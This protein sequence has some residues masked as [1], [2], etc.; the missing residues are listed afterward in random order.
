MGCI[1]SKRKHSSTHDGID[2]KTQPVRNTDRTIYVRDPTSNKQQRPVHNVDSDLLPGQ[3]FQSNDSEEEM[4]IAIYPYEGLHPDDLSFKKGEKMKVLEEYGEWWK[5]KSLST[6]KEGYI[7]SNYVAKLNSLETEDW[8]FKDI[9]RKDA[10]RQLLLPG[11]RVG[12]YLIRES[13]TL[14]GSFSLSVRDYD[15]LHGDVIK[16][17]KIRS[18]D[19]GGYYISPRITFP[20]IT[21]LIKHYQ[22]QPDGLCRRLDKACISTQPQKPWD[23]DAWEIPRESI[24]LVKKLGAGQFGEVWMG[25]YNG[26]TK[27][28]VKTLKPGTMSVQSFIEEANLMKTLQHEKLVRLYA[29]VTKEEPIY[30]VTEFMAKGSL[31]DFLKSGEGTK[32]L[33]PKLIDF[34]AQIA[35]GMA[36]L[37]RKNYIHRDL[38]A[39]NVLVSESLICKIA[40]FGLARIIRDDEYKARE[41]AKFPIKW[42]APEAINFGSFSIKSD[43]WSFGILIYEIITYGK[44]PYPGRTNAEVIMALGKGYRM[45]RMD[46]C[47]NELYDIMSMC[48]KER[49]EERP[50]FDY[51]QSVLEDYYTATEGQYQQQP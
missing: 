44:V 11:N 19:N 38:R 35:E 27:V 17:Y 49:A 33:L 2:L 25:Y 1:K 36:F 37:E 50:T 23:K 32:L 28:A 15:P 4:V 29:V 26:S 51:L 13:E 31:L 10:E 24:K 8:F 41:G 12:A 22:R 14:K 16:H 20:T 5:A 3:R 47:P 45:P 46:S 39:A 48:W 34:S 6:K 18:L 9:T 7:P 40:D 42:T 43:V 21:D 30:I